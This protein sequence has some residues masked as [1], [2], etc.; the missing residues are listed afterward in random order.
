VVGIDIGLRKTGIVALDWD[1]N[2]AR[3]ER[4]ETIRTVK[5]TDD[6]WTID[7]ICKKILSIRDGILCQRSIV[8]ALEAYVYQGEE[9]HNY[10]SFRVSRLLGHVERCLSEDRVISMR[11]I[12]VLH[13]LDLTG[14]TPKSVVK[15]RVHSLLGSKL[16]NEH[17]RDAA[18]VA[19]AVLKQGV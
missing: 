6:R 5:G 9:S 17:E 10:G 3:V 1:L 15:E 13:V 4:H 11:R 2:G 7:F 18:A 14:K 8:W 19:L 16:P 12:D